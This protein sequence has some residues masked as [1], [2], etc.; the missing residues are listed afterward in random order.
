[1]PSLIRSETA[2]PD[3]IEE[4]H[5]ALQNAEDAIEDLSAEIADLRRRA[6]RGNAALEAVSDRLVSIEDDEA[7]ARHEVT[8]YRR[9][10]RDARANRTHV[11]TIRTGA[12]PL[13]G[14]R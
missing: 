14:A 10:A 8:H 12:Q 2:R 9:A 5:A 4:C 11:A 13:A 7:T 3:T 1:M 6:R